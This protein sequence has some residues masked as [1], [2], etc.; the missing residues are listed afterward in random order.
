MLKISGSRKR[1][2]FVI[3]CTALVVAGLGWFLLIDRSFVRRDPSGRYWPTNELVALETVEHD[4][5]QALLARY[6]DKEGL[7]D[8]GGW[9]SS[10]ADLRRLHEYLEALSRANPDEPASRE[11]RI[12][13]WINAYNALTLEGILREY[14]TDSIRDHTSSVGGYNLWKDLPLLVGNQPYSLDAIE[15]EVLRRLG[16]PRIHFAI[17]CAARGC[18]RLRDEAYIADRLDEQLADNARNFFSR[19]GN[20]QFNNDTLWLNPI[21]DWFGSDFGATPADQI[22]AIRE[23]FPDEVQESLA[24]AVRIRYLTYDWSL[25]RQ[26]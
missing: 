26:E 11:A 7:V 1:V 20:L 22:A 14:P 6:V 5:F 10:R 2:S 25:N 16:E 19:A 23:Y 3:G 13:F 17:V 8:Y 4:V 18:P 9:K 12:A 21:L 15:H 24:P